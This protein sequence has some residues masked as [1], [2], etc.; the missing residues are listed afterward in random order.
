MSKKII[1]IVS[2]AA[3]GVCCLT[4]CSNEAAPEKEAK[5][6]KKITVAEVTHSVF[7]APQYVAMSQGFFEEEG[8]EIDLDKCSR[9]R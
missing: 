1:S 6:L 7:Y 5:E 9:C 3:L 4:G 8:L 2:A